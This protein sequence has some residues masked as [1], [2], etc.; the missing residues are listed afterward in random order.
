[1]AL[2]TCEDLTL[3]YD[4]RVAV[5][6]ITC[7][8]G[9]GDY[10]CVVGGNGSGKTTFIKG[11][12]GLLKVHAGRLVFDESIRPQ[13]IGYLPQQITIQRNFPAIV[14]EVVISGRL[15]RLGAVP[16]YRRE[17]RLAAKRSL[18][19]LG[20]T[21]LAKLSF[22]ELSGGQQQR[23]LLA[24]TLCSAPDGL[25][26][27][28]LDEPMN[29]LDP[30]VRQ[31]LYTSIAELNQVQGIT[32]IM[33]THDVQAAVRF[34][35]HILVLEAKQEFFGTSHEFEHTELGQELMRDSCGGNCRI[36]GT[37]IGD[38]QWAS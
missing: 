38:A 9:Q 36:C 4:G 10:L 13:D 8:L 20:I 3:S 19:L 5:S 31:G 17:D 21:D 6:G 33:V 22:S 26:L 1:M 2:I 30:H 35:S 14:R 34:A 24:R 25:K 16:F 7:T 12:L 27:L 28:I 29:G 32:I 15:S 11:L 23:V 18:E 37:R